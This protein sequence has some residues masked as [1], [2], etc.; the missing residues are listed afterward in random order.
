MIKVGVALLPE[1]NPAQDQRWSRVEAYG[2]AHAWSLEHLAWRAFVNSDWHATVPTLAAAALSTSRLTLGT[3]V[4][5]PNFRHPVPFAKELMTLDVMS[6][7]R[8]MIGAGAGGP[9]FDAAVLGGPSLSGR[10][11]AD[12]FDEFVT[13]LDLLHRTGDRPRL[14]RG[15]PVAAP[16]GRGLPQQQIE[17]RDEL[18]EPIGSLPARE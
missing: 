2:F 1:V 11:R 13:L 5:S 17:Q 4:A 16:G 7:G 9:G 18:L 10:E 3:F 6:G 15:E 8:I 14:D 12:R